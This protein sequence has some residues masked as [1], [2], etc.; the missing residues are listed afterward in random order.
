MSEQLIFPWLS[1]SVIASLVLAAWAWRAPQAESARRI[2]LIALVI[3][4]VALLAASLQAA[5]LSEGH[6]GSTLHEPF[7]RLF[8]VDALNAIPLP[9]FAALALGVMSFAPRRKVTPHWVAGVLLLSA[10]TF[11]AYATTNLALFAVAWIASLV[12]FFVKRFFNV[13]G[14]SEMPKLA[15]AIL[16]ASCVMV[17]TA[18]ILIAVATTEGA[19]FGMTTARAGNA[20]LLTVAFA[21]LMVAVFLRKGLLPAHTWMLASY[22]RGPLL[23]LT[24]LVNSHLGAFLIARFALPA[25]PDVARE[26]LPILG[27]LGLATALY[28][29]VLAFAE[30]QPRRLLALLSISQSSFILV[31]LESANADGITGALIHWQVVA[32]ATTMLA[33]VYTAIEARL[34]TPWDG[35]KSLGLASSAPRLAVFFAAGGLALVGLPLTLGFAAEDLLLHGTLESHPHLGFILALVTALNAFHV[36][37]LFIRLFL[38]QPG[39]EARAITDVLPRERW[40]LTAALLFLVLGGLR[41]M[42][43]MRLP[44]EAAGRLAEAVNLIKHDTARW[45]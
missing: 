6:H 22:E 38:G 23:P 19:R 25:L 5:L 16:I 34:A 12:P 45:R 43:L 2:G 36:L 21:L 39:R 1:L 14:E 35:V 30:R 4:F 3:S 10:A 28:A 8:V 40:A 15:R 29:A 33:L 32:V 11:V 41:P 13:A 27:D 42:T 37:R 26:A 31:G 18:V 44:A 9:L 24:L 7:I 20:P 17:V